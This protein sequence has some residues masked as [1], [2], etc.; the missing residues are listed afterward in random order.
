M[1][2]GDEVIIR[3]KRDSGYVDKT[4]VYKIVLDGDVVDKIKD[5][6]QIQLDITPGNHQLY[7]KIDWCR[8]NIVEFK[9]NEEIIEFECGSNLRDLKFWIPFIELIYIIFKRN[10]YIWLRMKN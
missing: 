2:R 8:S 6:Q 7:L 10:Q 5:G 1:L 9:M 4:R 3:I